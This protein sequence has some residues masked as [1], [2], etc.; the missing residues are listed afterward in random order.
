MTQASLSSAG[1]TQNQF[2][3]IGNASL[4]PP[5]IKTKSII[6]VVYASNAFTVN[7]HDSGCVY[8]VPANGSNAT[9]NL[10]APASCPMGTNY[11]FIFNASATHTTAFTSA[12]ASKIYGLAVSPQNATTY[13][14]YSGATTATASASVVTG[15]SA[16]FWTDQTNWYINAQTQANTTW[17]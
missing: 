8:L 2:S 6:T 10:P 16:D 15:D 7:L 4:A 3:A 5:L 14:A 11:K 17:S 1:S 13:H 12:T 9:I